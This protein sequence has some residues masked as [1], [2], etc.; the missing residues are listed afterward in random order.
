MSIKAKI[1]IKIHEGMLFSVI[2]N[3]STVAKALDFKTQI[4]TALR[5]SIERI[6][7]V[8]QGWPP[9]NDLDW[10]SPDE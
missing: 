9:L 1:I 6:L 10:E 8:C 7:S 4:S 3:R 2:R 5:D